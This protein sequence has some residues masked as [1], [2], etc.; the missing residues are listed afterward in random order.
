MLH[1]LLEIEFRQ[2]F[3]RTGFNSLFTYMVE[4]LR[5]SPA[6]ASSHLGAMRVLKA[7]PEIEA[8]IESGALPLSNLAQVNSFFRC[9]D[10]RHADQ[11]REVLARVAGKSV[12]EVQKI[13]AAESSAPEKLVFEKVRPAGPNLH[14]VTFAITD[15]ELRDI[16]ALKA[17]LSHRMPDQKLRDLVMILVAELRCV[18]S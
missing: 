1:R 11:K 4:E 3:A 6:T 18:T 12:R 8:K 9:E 17:L 7:V 5:Y 10:I 15:A 2:L 16:E 14:T 13:L